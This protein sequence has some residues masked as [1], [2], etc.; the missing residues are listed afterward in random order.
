M[1]IPSIQRNLLYIFTFS[2]VFEGWNILQ[3]GGISIPKVIAYVLVFFSLFNF[4]QTFSV[5]QQRKYLI[6]LFA[7]SAILLISYVLNQDRSDSL[8]FLLFMILQNVIF[9]WIATNI[10]INNPGTTDKVLLL[11]NLA[12][13]LSAVLFLFGIGAE[14]EEGRLTIFGENP[15]RIGLFS[16]FSILFIFSLILENTQNYRKSRFLLL[17]LLIPLLKM[18]ALSGSR[19]TFFGLIIALVTFFIIKSNRNFLYKSLT[20]VFGGITIFALYLYLMSFEVLRERL[21]LAFTAG[22]LSG[23]DV[24]WEYALPLILKKPILGLGVNGYAEIMSYRYGGF[25]SPHNVF[26]EIF[27]YGGILG[28]IAYFTFFFQIGKESYNLKKDKNYVLPLTYTILLLFIYLSGQA[29]AVKSFWII[30]A[31]IATAH[32]IQQKQG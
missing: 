25:F 3:L 26:I 24:I 32:K 5:F 2:L 23:R 9:F 29:L 19:V 14:L 4:K 15:N 16:V 17:L 20:L 28:L 21:S 18:A 22:D 8:F 13:L 6:P 10:M 11:L 27:A 31:Y 12:I 30:Y 7:F 1:K